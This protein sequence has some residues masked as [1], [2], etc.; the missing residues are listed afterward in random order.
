MAPDLAA[1]RDVASRALLIMTLRGPW[2][3]DSA[4]GIPGGCPD[5]PRRPAIAK[6]GKT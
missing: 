5:T 2:I 4:A 3:P 6:A 1:L